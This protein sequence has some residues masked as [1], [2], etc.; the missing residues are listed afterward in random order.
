MPQTKI[1]KDEHSLY[2]RTEG[3]IYR[4]VMPECGPYHPRAPVAEKDSKFSQGDAVYVSM[5]SQSPWARIY[6]KGRKEDTLEIWHSHGV[7]I[8]SGGDRK[9]SECW[10][11]ETA[12]RGKGPASGIHPRTRSIRQ[13]PAKPKNS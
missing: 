9:S 3:R 1:R 11:P 2:F 10:R 13:M 6:I 12:I 5:V 7:Y 4:P 8:R